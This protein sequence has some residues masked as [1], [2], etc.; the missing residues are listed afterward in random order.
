MTD[1]EILAGLTECRQTRDR[2]SVARD[3][4][5][6]LQRDDS[7]ESVVRKR[8]MA[9]CLKFTKRTEEARVIMEELA[10]SEDPEVAWQGE[11]LLAELDGDVD[12]IEEIIESRAPSW[13]TLC[14]E[15]MALD[16]MLAKVAET[17]TMRGL[18]PLSAAVLTSLQKVRNTVE[19]DEPRLVDLVPQLRLESPVSAGALI[20]PYLGEDLQR[21]SCAQYSGPLVSPEI[22][23]LTRYVIEMQELDSTSRYS[24]ERFLAE[25]GK[26]ESQSGET[27]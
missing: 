18:F 21:R 17:C 19:R 22:L 15:L 16:R 8:A 26:R 10:Q 2:A 6:R 4:L 13:E 3:L 27:D 24:L 14:Q 7:N 12:R 20:G 9:L 1:E 5:A 23:Q 25:F 11:W